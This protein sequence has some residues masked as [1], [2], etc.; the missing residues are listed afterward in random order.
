MKSWIYIASKEFLALTQ[1]IAIF[2]TDGILEQLRKC[3]SQYVDTNPEL[4][5]KQLPT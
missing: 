2:N 1:T 4:F 3:M 5:T